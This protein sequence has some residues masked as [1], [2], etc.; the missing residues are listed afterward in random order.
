[1]SR[2]TIFVLLLALPLLGCSGDRERNINRDRDRP[3]SGEQE[4]AKEK[5]SYSPCGGK[6]PNL[7][8]RL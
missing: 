3:K 4:K 2:R 5:A 8:I 7:P 6:F 1:M